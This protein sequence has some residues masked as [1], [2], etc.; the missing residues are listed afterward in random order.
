MNDTKIVLNKISVM[1]QEGNEAVLPQLLEL[2]LTYAYQQ[3]A[4]DIH[5]EAGVAHARIRLRQDGFLKTL[6]KFNVNL[7][8][9]LIS[10]LKVIAELDIAERRLPQ[11]GRFHMII[12]N[13]KREYRLSTCPQIHAEKAVLR[14]V[15]MNE[16]ILKL[17]ELGLLPEQLTMLQKIL[18][19]PHGLILVSGP[20]GSGKTLS[21]YAMLN[22]LNRDTMN[23]ISVEDPVELIL[24]GINQI[25]INNK[26]GI[27]F[28]NILRAILRQDPDIIMIGEIRDLETAELAIKAAQTGHLVLATVHANSAWDALLRLEHLGISHHALLSCVRLLLA[29][30]LVRCFCNN[31]SGKGCEGCVEGYKG[32]TGIFELIPLSDQVEALKAPEYLN[33]K[34]AGIIKV[35]Q[36]LTS[37][38]EVDRVV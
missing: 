38:E 21:Q 5:I 27:E 16:Q 13:K 36:G 10:R 17:S 8:H 4:S 18:T 11:D 31:C 26:T 32:R 33:L 14:L 6:V 12:D 24:P 1:A 3:K 34:A 9:P 25:P 23:L 19:K 7:I 28:Q 37:L 2:I 29:Q 30:R 15:N 35:N 22:F 20:T